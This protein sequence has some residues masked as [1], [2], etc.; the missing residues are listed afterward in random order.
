MR[1]TLPLKSPW[2]LVNI[3]KIEFD[4]LW[5]LYF[6]L[7]QVSPNIP[8]LK[9]FRL[10]LL[11]NFGLKVDFICEFCIFNENVFIYLRNLTIH[12]RRKKPNRRICP[13]LDL[14][15]HCV[16]HPMQSNYHNNYC[17]N[18][19]KESYIFQHMEATFY[20]KTHIKICFL[21][22]LTYQTIGGK[23]PYSI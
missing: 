13:K 15:A 10:W 21:T 23:A 3:D 8:C 1:Q 12:L 22:V 19:H 16:C 11:K 17:V 18:W 7:N 6:Y 5:T 20:R 9:V 14:C 4:R 2:T